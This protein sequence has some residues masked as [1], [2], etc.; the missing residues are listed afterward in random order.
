M[1]MYHISENLCRPFLAETILR[2][3]FQIIA[4][5]ETADRGKDMA[6][7]QYLLCEDGLPDHNGLLLSAHHIKILL[8]KQKSADN[9]E[10][11]GHSKRQGK[12]VEGLQLSADDHASN[13]SS[14][15]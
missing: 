1:Y 14:L 7:L 12:N 8:C 5:A 10:K 4:V 15:S 3:D 13:A 2:K 9:N 6:L 11:G